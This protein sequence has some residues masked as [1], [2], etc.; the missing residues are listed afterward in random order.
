MI[1]LDLSRLTDQ[2][3]VAVLSCLILFSLI[4]GLYLYHYPKILLKSLKE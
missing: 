2:E 1:S 4:G 3:F